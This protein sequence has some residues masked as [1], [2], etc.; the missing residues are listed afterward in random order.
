MTKYKLIIFSF[1][2]FSLLFHLVQTRHERTKHNNN[3]DDNS[4]SHFEFSIGSSSGNFSESQA[5]RTLKSAPWSTW[6]EI[7]IKYERL[8]DRTRDPKK[9][10]EIEKAFKFF[11][12]KKKEGTFKENTLFGVIFK[13]IQD[14]IIFVGI[15]GLIYFIAKMAFKAQEYF[16]R[17]IFYQVVSFVIFERFL[18]HYFD[19]T[20]TQYL[21]AFL[22]GCIVCFRGKI[23][24]MIFGK[25]EEVQTEKQTHQNLH[26]E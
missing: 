26:K 5:F 13:G 16:N 3:D 9:L 4:G 20:F 10:E 12:D 6:E 8:R 18:P 11:K 17:F 25:K 24:N 21:C 15:L 14:S 7:K 19:Q 22:V 2:S 1:I 23:F